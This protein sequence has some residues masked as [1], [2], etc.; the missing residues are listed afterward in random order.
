M[1]K[2]IILL[3]KPLSTK[4]ALEDVTFPAAFPVTFDVA[5]GGTPPPSES[6]EITWDDN[7]FITWDNGIQLIWG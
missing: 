5:G 6:I 3:G 1:Q 2:S 7:T 4:H